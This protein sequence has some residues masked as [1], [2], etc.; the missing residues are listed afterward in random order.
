MKSIKYGLLPLM[1][2]WAVSCGK[3]P[4]P[5]QEVADE[6][7]NEYLMLYFDTDKNGELSEAE[8]L[9]VEEMDC[10]YWGIRSLEGISR[11]SNLRIL[12]CYSNLLQ[13][14]D[15]SMLKKLDTLYCYRNELE[16]LDVSG[17]ASLRELSCHTNQ[18]TELD[19]SGCVSLRAL[20]C[21]TN[22]LT[23]L[24][25]DGCSALVSLV[26]SSNSLK[27]LEIR[28][29]PALQYVSCGDNALE[30]L[31]L[32][33]CT[34]LDELY[35]QGGGTVKEVNLSGCSSLGGLHLEGTDIDARLGLESL[36]LNGCT[37]LTSL[38]CSYNLLT[39]LD[40]SDCTALTYLDCSYNQLTS[41]NLE[42]NP[43]LEVGNSSWWC[44]GNEYHVMTTNNRFD[45]SLLPGDF[46]VAK[47]S[48]WSGGTV[49]G[50]I[51]TFTGDKTNYEGQVCASYTYQTGYTGEDEDCKTVR[52]TLVCDNFN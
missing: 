52:F 26:A 45:L 16:G 27:R 39:V 49:K 6:K 40:V 10:S 8:I 25:V 20:S 37:S 34:A 51:L 9:A 5:K 46:E 22:Q 38:D 41:L 36:N 31:D 44:D 42:N 29:H 28:N 17:C 4:E 12:H 30:F 32:S 2:V 43:L 19:V 21:H 7:F 18:L 3:E 23:E 48:D 1:V 11:F 47:A 33:G 14:L 13:E 35:F 24:D 50:N 15:V